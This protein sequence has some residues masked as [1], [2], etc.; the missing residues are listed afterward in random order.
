MTTSGCHKLFTENASEVQISAHLD[1]FFCM[2]HTRDRMESTSLSHRLQ[3][4]I[5]NG[6][7]FPPTCSSF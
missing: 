3:T 5:S 4:A 2:Q 6:I 1:P 7:W